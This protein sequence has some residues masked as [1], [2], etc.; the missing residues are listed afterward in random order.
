MISWSAG[1]FSEYPRIFL[2]RGQTV[3]SVLKPDLRLCAKF[4]VDIQSE[5]RSLK[6]TVLTTEPS[7]VDSCTMAVSRQMRL[8][9]AEKQESR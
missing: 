1:S 2:L 5:H 7:R 8:S 3:P 4:S 9:L 6:K